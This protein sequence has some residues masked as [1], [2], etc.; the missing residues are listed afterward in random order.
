MVYVFGVPYLSLFLFD[1]F[2]KTFGSV[3]YSLT[4]HLFDSTGVQAAVNSGQSFVVVRARAPNKASAV[5]PLCFRESG[6]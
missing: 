5:L 4:T 6:F 1:R 2:V 3:S